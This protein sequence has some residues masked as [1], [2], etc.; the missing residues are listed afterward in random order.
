MS[1]LDAEN[2]PKP[3]RNEQA[4]QASDKR[5]QVV[6][7]PGTDHAFEEL[8]A[9]EDPDPIQEHDQYCQPDWSGDLGFGCE[10]TDGKA[11]EKNGADAERKSPD[12]DLTDQVAQSDRE[13]RRQYRLASDDLASKV[14]HDVQSPQP[15]VSAPGS[16]PRGIARSP[17]PP[18]PDR[19]SEYR[20]VCSRAPS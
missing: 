10:R 9:V 12:T 19:Q 16:L 11:H 14:Q 3:K 7:L 15:V 5:Q 1:D 13:K 2:V 20:E 6:L 17:D 4:G 8:P 18:V